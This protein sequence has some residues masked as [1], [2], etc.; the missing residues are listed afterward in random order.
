MKS[1][2]LRAMPRWPNCATDCGTSIS[3]IC[4]RRAERQVWRRPPRPS[5]R[6]GRAPNTRDRAHVPSAPAS[7]SP[8]TGDHQL[9]AGEHA[10]D[11]GLRSSGEMAAIEVM[12]AFDRPAVRVALK[13]E[14]V[15]GRRGHRLGIVLVEFQAGQDLRTHPRRWPSLPGPQS[16]WRSRPR[17]ERTSRLRSRRWRWRSGEGVPRAPPE[18]PRDRTPSR[19]LR[20]GRRASRSTTGCRGRRSRR[21]T[22][23]RRWCS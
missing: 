16:R 13:G 6:G 19:P 17:T 23:S 4:W 18:L 9:V 7:M 11:I 10:V 15:P 5:A 3:M 1:S 22:S 14:P 8:T 21:R 12:R 20:G 2:S